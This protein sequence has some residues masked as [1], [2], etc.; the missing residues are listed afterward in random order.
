MNFV[1]KPTGEPSSKRHHK[2]D[3]A[4]A[5]AAGGASGGGNGNDGDGGGV[6]SGNGSSNISKKALVDALK[7]VTETASF[8]RA[9]SAVTFLTFIF[10]VGQVSDA[11]IQAGQD[12]A[13]E[14]TKGKKDKFH[15][16]IK[17]W[18]ALIVTLNDMTS[19]FI[20]KAGEEYNTL[21]EDDRHELADANDTL[22]THRNSV[23]SLADLD[24]V[25]L[26]C[27]SR[28]HND[29]S[30]YILIISA[31]RHHQ[32]VKAIE[33]VFCLLLKT[34]PCIGTAPPT[35]AER[36]ARKALESLAP[37]PKS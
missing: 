5:S 33:T 4:V 13:K 9:L 2:V 17:K 6:G 10:A 18:C 19:E 16:G 21:S 36:G 1:M 11:L 28:M 25:Q 12:H 3:A 30:Q 14:Q 7:C 31:P 27:E 22:R 15:A 23:S 8:A 20:N 26:H 24:A 29:K 32:V 35:K 34:K 37:K